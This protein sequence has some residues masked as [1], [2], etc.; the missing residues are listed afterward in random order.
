MFNFKDTMTG[1]SQNI[2]S[3]YGEKVDLYVPNPN[4]P[5]DDLF[6]PSIDVIINESKPSKGEFN[7]ITGYHT[8]IKVL[9]SDL[10]T[11][12]TSTPIVRTQSGKTYELGDVE[13]RTRTA[14][15]FRATT[16]TQTVPTSATPDGDF[17][18]LDVVD[19]VQ[20]TSSVVSESIEYTYTWD[21]GDG[22]TATGFVVTHAYDVS[23]TYTV[24]HNATDINGNI[25]YTS[26]SLVIDPDNTGEI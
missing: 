26:V 12:P 25:K 22:N 2:N 21:F 18:T 14:Y 8:V 16:T 10:P 1:L 7:N 24:L 11:I 4:D 3:I 20:F 17:T 13:E 23:G 15:W 19:G 9:I 6:L 5:L